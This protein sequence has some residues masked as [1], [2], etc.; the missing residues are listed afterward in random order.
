MLEK[1]HIVLSL[2]LCVAAEV[3]KQLRQQ[4]GQYSIK[5]FE[6]CYIWHRLGFTTVMTQSIYMYHAL[7]KLEPLSINS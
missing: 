5:P 2:R 7:S 1:Q 6:M 4:I 3:E